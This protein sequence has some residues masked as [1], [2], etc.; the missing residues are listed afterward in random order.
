MILRV[1]FSV[2]FIFPGS[3]AGQAFEQWMAG[4]APNADSEQVLE[5]KAPILSAPPARREINPA[6]TLR[7]DEQDRP[8]ERPDE[9]PQ[10]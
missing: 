10:S 3:R 8:A 2:L 9:A 6:L 7:A 1:L 5:P 4:M